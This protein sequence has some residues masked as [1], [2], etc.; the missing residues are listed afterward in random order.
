[1]KN[2]TAVNKNYKFLIFQH[3]LNLGKDPDPDRHQNYADPQRWLNGRCCQLHNGLSFCLV[4]LANFSQMNYAQKCPDL[5]GS[6]SKS[7]P[8]IVFLPGFRIRINLS[9]WIRIRIQIADPN[10]G[11]QK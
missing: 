7:T 3:V 6:L 5:Y 2:D 4:Q 8:R 11:G 10:P 1:M 9:C